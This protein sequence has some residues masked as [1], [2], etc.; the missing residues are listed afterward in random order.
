MRKIAM[1]LA[2]GPV[3]LALQAGP[4]DD[5]DEAELPPVS[6][7]ERPVTDKVTDKKETPL[8]EGEIVLARGWI[9]D[10]GAAAFATRETAHRELLALGRKSPGEIRKLLPADSSD[11]EVQNRCTAIREALTDK[12]ETKALGLPFS[13]GGIPVPMGGNTFRNNRVRAGQVAPAAINAALRVRVIEGEI[14]E[15]G[16]PAEPEG[17]EKKGEEK[18]GPELKKPAPAGGLE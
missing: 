18:K 8:T 7:P 17:T 3:A 2:L 10:L 16:A 9:R 13:P 1:A 6:A 5:K 11:A 15:E 12:N 4:M 14:Q